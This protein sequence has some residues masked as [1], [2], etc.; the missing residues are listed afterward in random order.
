MTT[1]FSLYLV[2]N[3][4]YIERLTVSVTHGISDSRYQWL[5]VSVMIGEMWVVVLSEK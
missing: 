4:V 2:T 5:T 1:L 3:V